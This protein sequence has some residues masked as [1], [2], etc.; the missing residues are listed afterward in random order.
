MLAIVR[1]WLAWFATSWMEFCRWIWLFLP[2]LRSS[3]GSSSAT[4]VPGQE[5]GWMEL[6]WRYSTLALAAAGAFSVG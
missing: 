2:G 1:I 4:A 5:K 6:R 3:R